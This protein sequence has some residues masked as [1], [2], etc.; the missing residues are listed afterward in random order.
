MQ[1]KNRTKQ[2]LIAELSSLRQRI[3]EFEHQELDHKHAEEKLR[4]SEERYKALFERSLYLVYIF[5]F[6]GRFIDA[7][8]VYVETQ[9]STITSNGAPVAILAIARDVTERRRIE[10]ELARAHDFIQN[11]EDACFEVNLS[12]KLI[13]CNE[14]FLRITGYT[15]EEYS[16]LSSRD[17]YPTPEEYKRVYAGVK[18]DDDPVKHDS[19]LRLAA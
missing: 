18:F 6:E 10:A 2:D 14:P 9:G 3:A 7:T 12:G 16:S 13:F 8:Q 4:D 15:F 1:D 11:V 5:D 19:L 17:L